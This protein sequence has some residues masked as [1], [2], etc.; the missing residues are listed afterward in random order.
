M[1]QLRPLLLLSALIPAVQIAAA[2]VYVEIPGVPGEA[3][4]VDHQRWIAATSMQVGVANKICSGVT[5]AKSLDTSSPVLS[6]AALTGAIYS[7]VKI[8]V[9]I[10]GGDREF[11]FLKYLLS[12]V[13]VNSISA[14][15]VSATVSESVTLQ[16]QTL[17]MTYTPSGGGA[18]VS[19]TLNC[20]K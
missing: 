10:P 2:N 18:P 7:T 14:N 8:E 12:N 3:E 17:T 16:A 15:V 5:L 20:K 19:F 4:H 6:A 13:T 9:T 11:V 1:K